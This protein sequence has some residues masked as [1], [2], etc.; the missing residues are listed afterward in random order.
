MDGRRGRAEVRGVTAWPGLRAGFLRVST[1]GDETAVKFGDVGL[2]EEP[3][4]EELGSSV[5]G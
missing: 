3:V 1:R 2:E 4:E 5:A